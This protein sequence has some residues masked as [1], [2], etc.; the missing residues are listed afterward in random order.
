MMM[1]VIRFPDATKGHAAKTSLF[2][3]MSIMAGWLATATSTAF[4]PV[5][6]EEEENETA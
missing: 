5:Q 6:E 4:V 3:D 1:L 2:L